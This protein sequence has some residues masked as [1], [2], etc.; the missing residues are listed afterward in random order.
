MHRGR[1]LRLDGDD[2]PV[3]GRGDA[4]DETAAADRDHDRLHLRHVLQQLE[5]HRS[6]SRDHEWVVERVHERATALGDQ[7]LQAGERR[8]RPTASR[9]TTA[10]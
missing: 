8:C 5:R 9:S 2:A 7:L 4:G 1:A 6:L 3:G 10:P